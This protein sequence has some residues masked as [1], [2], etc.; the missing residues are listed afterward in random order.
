MH[1]IIKTIESKKTKFNSNRKNVSKE[2]SNE[3]ELIN[4]DFELT[5]E[6]KIEIGIA[7]VVK[8]F[9]EIV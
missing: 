6:D 8:M 2:K 3:K 4:I 7:T 5:L 9:N 1:D